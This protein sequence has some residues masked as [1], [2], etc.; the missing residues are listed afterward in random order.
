M[1][2]VSC[3]NKA[4]TFKEIPDWHKGT[5][6]DSNYI[7]LAFCML[8]AVTIDCVILQHL[9]TH[10]TPASHLTSLNASLCAQHTQVVPGTHLIISEV[11]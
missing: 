1:L 5:D 9:H 4:N 6:Y 2:P 3:H 11:L 7:I 10:L 8:S